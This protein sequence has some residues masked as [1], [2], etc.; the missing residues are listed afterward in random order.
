V[1]CLTDPVVREANE[2]YL[3]ERFPTGTTDCCS[4]S[5]SSATR[6]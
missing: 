4:A 5:P 3:D 1:R 2:Q 6:R